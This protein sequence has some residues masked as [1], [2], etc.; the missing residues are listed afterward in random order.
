MKIMP[1]YGKIVRKTHIKLMFKPQH[2]LSLEREKRLLFVEG[3]SDPQP[4][5]TQPDPDFAADSSDPDAPEPT[6]AERT[7][8]EPQTDAEKAIAA[9]AGDAEKSP[10]ERIRESILKEVE[11]NTQKQV[12]ALQADL[13]KRSK[14]SLLGKVATLTVAKKKTAN[15]NLS[16]AFDDITKKALAQRN[17]SLLKS[18]NKALH[19]IA[20]STTGA[21]KGFIFM[22]MKCRQIGAYLDALRKQREIYQREQDRFSSLISSL[23][24]GK[25]DVFAGEIAD[26]KALPKG[27]N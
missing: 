8:V 11:E 9:F 19:R 27:N 6:G 17:E 10:S 1:L 13:E 14:L 2:F 21:N 22:E 7:P 18:G 16:D 25:N 4:L 26:N 24:S 12:E 15:E 20:E 23:R 5:D 3:G